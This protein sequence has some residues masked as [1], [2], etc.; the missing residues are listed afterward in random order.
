MGA[1]C[2]LFD[3]VLCPFTELLK[4]K[5][6][7]NDSTW[8]SSILELTYTTS[9]E[10]KQTKATTPRAQTPTRLASH[11][12]TKSHADTTTTDA[13]GRRLPAYTTTSRQPLQYTLITGSPFSPA[14][15]KVLIALHEKD[16]PYTIRTDVPWTAPSAVPT[17]PTTLIARPPSPSPSTSSISCSSCPPS[18][19][20]TLALLVPPAGLTHALP[21]HDFRPLLAYL[22]ASQ[23][24][25]SANADG[26]EHAAATS[27]PLVATRPEDERWERH[28]EALAD[29]VTE[30]LMLLAYADACP[31][32]P[33]ARTDSS[34]GGIGVSGATNGTYQHLWQHKMWRKVDEGLRRLEAVVREVG[35]DGQGVFLNGEGGDFGVAD[36][37]VGVLGGLLDAWARGDVVVGGEGVAT[38]AGWRARFA[39]LA[40]FVAGLERRDSFKK[41]RTLRVEVRL[42]DPLDESGRKESLDADDG[43]DDV[44]VPRRVVLVSD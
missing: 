12:T 4:R 1:L 8:E 6:Q 21:I 31:Q 13:R 30:T 43:D 28:I 29:G 27:P 33:S 15:R 32:T 2:F 9:L 7:Q 36:L 42:Q 26:T 38:L 44:E 11:S 5:P 41:T 39:H 23:R 37:V 34:G 14:A 20:T 16:L 17:I 35:A 18:P 25:D 3:S 24:R 19:P 10:E 22:E 40:A